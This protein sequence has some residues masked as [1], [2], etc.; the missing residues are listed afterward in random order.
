MRKNNLDE[1]QEQK[2]LK[3]EHNG[4]W[5]AYWGLFASIFIQVIAEKDFT[6]EFTIFMLLSVYV[7]VACLKNGIWDRRLKPTLK[8]N[9]IV[10]LIGALFVGAFQIAL[11]FKELGYID[12]RLGIRPFTN[13]LIICFLLMQFCSFLYKRKVNK[14]EETE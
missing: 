12:I 10:S 4:M 11:N 5:F 1:M 14:L 6:G 9:L 8:T 3:I 2:L 7:A 13:V